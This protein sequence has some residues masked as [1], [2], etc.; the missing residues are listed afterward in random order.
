MPVALKERKTSIKSSSS[1]SEDELA[2]RVAVIKRFKELLVQQRERFRSYL[3]VLDRHQLLIGYGNADEITAHV[4]LEEQIVADI[5]SIQK[6]IAPLEIMY[7]AI[8]PATGAA[9]DNAAAADLSD[10]GTFITINDVPELQATLED[11]KNQAVVRSGRNRDLIS[12]RMEEINSG[13]QKIKNNPFLSKARFSMY[14]NA[15]PA[16][17]DIM[18]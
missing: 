15:T 13:I 5:F 3:A 12:S 16:T 14:Q 9:A 6:V 1:I 18:G 11:L 17:I 7:N 2:Q 4:E 10:L 8:S